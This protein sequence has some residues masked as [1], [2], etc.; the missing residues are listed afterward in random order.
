MQSW[1]NRNAVFQVRHAVSLLVELLASSV[2]TYSTP[3]TIISV[4]CFEQPVDLSIAL[5]RDTGQRGQ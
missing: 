1:A 4:N 3:R 2:H 5:V